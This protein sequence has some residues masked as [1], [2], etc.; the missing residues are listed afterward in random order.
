MADNPGYFS[1]RLILVMG[2]GVMR[3]SSAGM[4]KTT[5]GAAFSLAW[6][7]SESG[8][9]CF[10]RKLTETANLMPNLFLSV[11]SLSDFEFLTTFL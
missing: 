9:K 7:Q 1:G 8:V 4:G 2:K 10:F 5:K 11:F 6:Q 3:S